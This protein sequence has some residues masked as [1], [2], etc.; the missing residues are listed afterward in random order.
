MCRYL[1]GIDRGTTNIKAAVY[2]L[3][4]N[5]IKVKSHPCEK[6]K[7][8]VPGYAEQDMEQMWKDTS[9]TIK[10]LWGD[11][12]V[13]EQI[14]AVGL[15][16]QGG[17]MFLIDENGTPIRKGIVSLDTRVAEAARVWKQEGSHQHFLELWKDGNPTVPEALLYWLKEYEYTQYSRTRWV[18]QCKDWIR[19][20]L[21]GEVYY[22][23]TDASNG[24]LLDENEN[25][26]FDFL[27]QYGL[28]EAAKMFPPLL[29]P[30]EKAG[31]ITD[32][33]AE[34]T[35]LCPGTLVAAGGHDVAMVALGAGCTKS[36][37]LATVLGTFGLNLLVIDKPHIMLEHFAKIVLSG[38]KDCYLMMNGGN[39]GAATEWFI[40]T[41]CKAEKNKA[42]ES[43]ENVFDIMEDE[44]L[45]AP[46]EGRSN[47]ICH[48]FAEPPFTL[49][50]WEHARFGIFGLTSD[51]TRPQIIRAFYEGIAIEMAMSLE[52]LNKAVGGIDVMRLI[53]GG[54]NSRLWGQMFADVCGIPVKILDIKE[55]GCRG[56]AFNAGI[57]AGI[58]K[59][60]K[61][62]GKLDDPV[63]C[64]Y[65]PQKEG[66]KYMREKKERFQ[67][68]GRLLINTWK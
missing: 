60:H 47:I 37:E 42:N 18:L 59:D 41:F 31:C 54:A 12:I 8:P 16:G 51:T 56:A 38:S 66:G 62:V 35:G 52:I 1:I 9:D 40:E 2:D 15:S 21:T 28:E 25:Y 3:K 33:A 4:G 48:P 57:A 50:G 39:T 13:P 17:G 7:N 58:Y 23:T 63:K 5:E 22:E 64:I 53:G 24:F 67:D 26:R 61:E 10:M 65:Y 30:W 55:A 11:G 36:G 46:H 27:N 43:A 44:V 32:Q 45:K 14:A 49:E 6:V 20:K 19:Y 34:E 29:R 68:L